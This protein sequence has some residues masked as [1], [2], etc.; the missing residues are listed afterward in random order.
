MFLFFTFQSHGFVTRV[1]QFKFVVEFV[2]KEMYPPPY[3]TNM[4]LIRKK[5]DTTQKVPFF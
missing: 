3:V 5:S 1:G 2:D 4:S